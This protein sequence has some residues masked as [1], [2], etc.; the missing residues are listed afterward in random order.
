[1][2][3]R[4]LPRA[5]LTMASTKNIYLDY[6]ATTP[7]APEVRRAMEPY[8]SVKFGNAGSLHAFGQ[9]AIAALDA[10][11]ETVACA[12][13]AE[14][15]E[16]IFTASATE[17]NNLAIRGVVNGADRR[18]PMNGKRP[19]RII[20]SAFEHESVRETVYGLAGE[21]T[22]I[23]II[24]LSK[25]GTVDVEAF[26]SALTRETILVSVM[27]ANNETGN[28]QPIREI[29]D[30]IA[31]LKRMRRRPDDFP[32]PLFH[33]DATQAF[34][35]LNCDVGMLGVDLLTISSHKIYG[36]KGAGAL[37]IKKEIQ[38]Q[39]TPIISGGGHEFGFRSGTENIPAIVG[40]AAA[41]RA[42]SFRSS[43]TRKIS[44]LRNELW[45]GIRNAVPR[46]EING[47]SARRGPAALPGTIL[48]NFLNVFFPGQG[49]QELL[50]RLDRIGIAA[51]SGS[52]CRARE[53]QPSYAIMALGHSSVRAKESIRFS[54]GWYTTHRDIRA[55]IEALKHI[56][57]ERSQA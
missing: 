39:L 53:H 13:G 14:F 45:K 32:G 3:V 46:A 5:Q 25:S 43:A 18:A 54:L 2:Q 52:A 48:P 55:T 9:E 24:P 57:A 10:S 20:L 11:R 16:I 23:V 29:A 12:L 35:F 41:D 42:V 27:Y 21:N 19:R 7:V 4:F 49:A 44:A 30:A 38:N 34:Q 15:R 8:F 22:E 50:T 26:K 6:A 56:T 28:I 47:V 51:S 36:P 31:V 33:T 40:F 37:Y 1:M 17:A